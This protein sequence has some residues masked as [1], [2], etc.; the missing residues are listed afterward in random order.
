[1][2]SKNRLFIALLASFLFSP[3]AQASAQ[4]RPTNDQRNFMSSMFGRPDTISRTDILTIY[5]TNF[6][7][8]TA[9]IGYEF[10]VAH[11]KGLKIMA[12]YGSSNGVDDFYL[13]DKFNEIGLEAQFRIYV[14]K[15]HLALNG[16]YLAPYISYK[17]MTY[18]GN[19]NPINL[20]LIYPSP[21]PVYYS[22]ATVAALGIGYVIGY[23]WIFN[24]TFTVDAYIGGGDNIISGNNAGGNLSGTVYEYRSGIDF[25]SGIGIGIA[26]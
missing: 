2:K 26:F 24:S 25:H 17:T 6:V 1:M 3:F 10:K 18:S 23:Q 21:S 12:S 19:S 16:L 11:N 20:D 13:L 14:L 5:P 9:K 15:N 8:S 4:S 22:N 7:A